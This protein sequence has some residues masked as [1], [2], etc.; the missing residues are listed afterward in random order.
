[1]AK[2]K[3]TTES[4]TSSSLIHDVV[5][6]PFHYSLDQILRIFKAL[7]P[8]T[9]PYKGPDLL[10]E[11]VDIKTKISLA[12]PSSEVDAIKIHEKKPV[13]VVNFASIAG[14]QGS[15]PTPYNELLMDRLRH[16]D[17]SFADFLDIF[18]HRLLSLR[19]FYHT[20]YFPCLFETKQQHSPLGQFQLTLCGLYSQHYQN[21]LTL[22]DEE[23][24][25]FFDLAWTRQK[26]ALGLCR[27]L[28]T[29][30]N[31]HVRLQQFQGQWN[32]PSPSDYSYLGLSGQHNQ[33]GKNLIVGKKSWEQAAGIQIEFARLPWNRL[34]HFYPIKQEHRSLGGSEFD[35]LKDVIRF[36]VGPLLQV[37]VKFSIAQHTAPPM[38]LNRKS[39]LGLSSWIRSSATPI[40]DDHVSFLIP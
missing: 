19:H 2:P 14:V 9:L 11:M 8:K 3:I 26:T 1:M 30:F 13:V 38:R 24:V 18:N 10:W 4:I 21:R 17:S 6:S 37:R 5:T 25:P 36:Y 31:I 40:K 22:Q 29:K 32:R 27:W 16:H 34:K 15:L 12:N 7:Y 35:A 23:I 39:F 33:L 20:T 28:K